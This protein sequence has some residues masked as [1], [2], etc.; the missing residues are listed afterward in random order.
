MN[1]ELAR[2]ELIAC[3]I[4]AET[5]DLFLVWHQDNPEIWREFERLALQAIERGVTEWG[6][7]GVMEVVRWNIRL[8]TRQDFKVN[9]NWTAIYARIFSMKYPQYRDFFKYREA[10]G[11][12]GRA[13]NDWWDK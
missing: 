3:G 9:N 8:Q 11:L 5:V 2:L 6:A 12:Q 10:K 1:L 13:V 7:K 4:N